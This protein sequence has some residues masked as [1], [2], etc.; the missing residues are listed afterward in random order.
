MEGVFALKNVRLY[1]KKTG[2]MKFVSHLD[3]N[4]Y[5][6]RLIKLTRLPV[7]YTE[8]FNQHIYLNFALPLS[9]GFESE[10]EIMDI[11]LLEDVP[12]NEIVEKAH[13][14]AA[15]GIEFFAAE[16]PQKKFG[17]IASADYVI[18]YLAD[19]NTAERFEEFLKLPEIMVQK[20]TKKGGF[21]EVDIAK[22]IN[23]STVSKNGGTITATFNLAAGG[24]ENLNP[25]LITE[26]FNNLENANIETV[27]VIRTCLYDDCGEVFK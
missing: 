27:S 6:A 17:K 9:L 10:Y 3:M 21:K 5:M 7:W 4:R 2:R 22:M 18:K 8:G 20:K 14:H 1:Y 13:A 25:A 16:E 23:S 19:E 11:R 26:A 15:R 12:F 24:S